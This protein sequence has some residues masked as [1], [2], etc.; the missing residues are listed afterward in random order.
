MS[1]QQE[2]YVIAYR[3]QRDDGFIARSRAKWHKIGISENVE[4]RMSVLSGGT[5]Y[6]LELVTTISAD[7]PQGVESYLHRFTSDEYGQGDEWFYLNSNQYNSLLALDE[8]QFENVKMAY[9]NRSQ[10]HWRVS[11]YVLIQKARN[12]ELKTFKEMV[13]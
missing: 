7:D 8:L 2:V 5:P 13:A 1:E 11:L 3:E 12:G 4:K 10:F 6:T 9:H